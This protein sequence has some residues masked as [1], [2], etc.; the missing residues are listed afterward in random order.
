M[1]PNFWLIMFCA[2]VAILG[3]IIASKKNKKK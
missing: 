2:T 3:G 1:H